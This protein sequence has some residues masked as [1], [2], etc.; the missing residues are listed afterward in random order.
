MR[1]RNSAKYWSSV[2]S[3]RA[4]A[5]ISPVSW[6][7]LG[8]R[9]LDDLLLGSR[10]GWHVALGRRATC[11]VREMRMGRRADAHITSHD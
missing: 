4:K 3:C 10:D 7:T 8:A 9:G 2:R 11:P 1:D 6:L 5:A